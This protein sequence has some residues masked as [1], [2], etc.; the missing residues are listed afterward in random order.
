MNEQMMMQEGSW[1]MICMI[2]TT[3]FVVIIGISV[4]LQ[5]ILQARML[6]ELRRIDKK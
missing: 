5:T 2:A 3:I 6:K 1:M 4:I